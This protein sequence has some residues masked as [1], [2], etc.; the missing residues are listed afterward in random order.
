MSDSVLPLREVVGEPA[1]V[2][3]LP[4]SQMDINTAAAVMT[5]LGNKL[6]LEIWLLLAP[7]GAAGLSAG[8]VAAQCAM[9]P[10]TISFHLQQM[11][12]IGALQT[13]QNG[14]HSIYSVQ[15]GV[16][17]DLCQF[18]TALTQAR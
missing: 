6:R 18:L 5:V 15:I 14:R 11:T 1:S 2:E 8:A 10:S 13:R 16:F 4:S 9:S 3:G 17:A 7:H 12:K